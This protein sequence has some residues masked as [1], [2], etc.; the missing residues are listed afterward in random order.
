MDIKRSKINAYLEYTA[1]KVEQDNTEFEDFMKKIASCNSEEERNDLFRQ[2]N[3]T[4]GLEDMMKKD[5]NSVLKT[6]K[7][8]IKLASTVSNDKGEFDIIEKY[9][10]AI[11]SEDYET[12]SQM[13]INIIE[14]EN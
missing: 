9:V 5:L 1:N 11:E 3:I 2:Y 4:H 14:D 8:L 6:T 13:N 12:L 10:N 7:S